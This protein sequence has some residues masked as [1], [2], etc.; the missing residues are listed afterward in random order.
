MAGFVLT[1]EEADVLTEWFP[2]DS[3]WRSSRE[4]SLLTTAADRCRA[5]REAARPIAVEDR[6]RHDGYGVGEVL[7]VFDQPGS[8]RR[9][10]VK[11]YDYEAP[12]GCRVSSLRRVVGDGA[13]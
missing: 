12:A 8:E 7:A 1:E 3:Q 13:R 11:F 2:V 6:V 5:E 9:C 4:G 10:W